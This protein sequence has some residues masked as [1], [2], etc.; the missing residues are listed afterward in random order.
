MIH[1]ATRLPPGKPVQV[2]NDTTIRKTTNFVLDRTFQFMDAVIKHFIH[3]PD[4]L[5]VPIYSYRVLS[6]KKDNNSYQYDMMRLG[7]LS[8]EERVL[9]DLASVYADRYSIGYWS[10]AGKDFYLKF[11]QHSKLAAFLEVVSSQGRYHDLHC[12]NVMMDMDGDYR[13]IDIEGFCNN[14]LE[15]NDNDWITRD[16]S[17][18]VT[19]Q[20]ATRLA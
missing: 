17:P 9:V 2:L 5:V 3:N 19:T 18:A 16:S 15:L 11:Q 7:L 12:G 10:K 13:L 4:P 20:R 14:P 6:N 1:Y 8:K